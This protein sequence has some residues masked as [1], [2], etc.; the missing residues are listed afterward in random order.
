[1]GDRRDG[2]KF[3]KLVDGM[4]V[5]GF[6]LIESGEGAS[7]SEGPVGCQRVVV[8]EASGLANFCVLFDQRV[9]LN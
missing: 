6:A 2:R 8:G 3:K 7:M 5:P 4:I 1:M 9:G